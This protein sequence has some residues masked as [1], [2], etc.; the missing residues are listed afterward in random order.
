MPLKKKVGHRC[1]L[2]VL[3]LTITKCN[4][5]KIHITQIS[6]AWSVTLSNRHTPRFLSALSTI[7][8]SIDIAAHII[9]EN[10]WGMP[11]SASG[12]FYVAE[13]NGLLDAELTKKKVNAVGPV[14]RIV[15]E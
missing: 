1:Q 13:K 12:M 9:S 11:G 7:E 14:N 8:N 5:D 2:E 15:H 4:L 10:G 3:K 6:N